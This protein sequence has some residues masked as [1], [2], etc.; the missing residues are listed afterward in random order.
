MYAVPRRT[1]GNRL[2]GKLVK[3]ESAKTRR[4]LTEVEDTVLREFILLQIELN[5]PPT[6][7]MIQR[8]A[9]SLVQRKKAQ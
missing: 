2:S 6:I 3:V 4:F 8:A 7:D 9:T 5:F 1:L